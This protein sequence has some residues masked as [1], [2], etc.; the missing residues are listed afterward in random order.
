MPAGLKD[1]RTPLSDRVVPI[2]EKKELDAALEAA[3]DRLVV[4]E[5]MRDSYAPP[6]CYRLQDLL[7]RTGCML[8]GD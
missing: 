7:L 8:P 2:Y 6:C 4:L 1:A 5:L 3:G